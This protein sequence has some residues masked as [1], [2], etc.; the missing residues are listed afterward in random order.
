MRSDEYADAQGRITLIADDAA[1]EPGT[2]ETERSFPIMFRTR[3]Q[4]SLK[5]SM[6]LNAKQER[7]DTAGISA[8]E[9]V[10]SDIPEEDAVTE[11]SRPPFPM[12][13][14]SPKKSCLPRLPTKNTS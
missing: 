8:A 14:L 3:N 12:S 5:L 2:E 4:N 1:D 7:P 10:T 6:K 13:E 9:D 11:R